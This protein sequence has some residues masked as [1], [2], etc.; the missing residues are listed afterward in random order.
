MV[1]YCLTNDSDK[2]EAVGHTNADV[3]EDNI[4]TSTVSSGGWNYY[5]QRLAPKSWLVAGSDGG[6]NNVVLT[7]KRRCSRAM[8]EETGSRTPFRSMFSNLTEILELVS[9]ESAAC[10]IHDSAMIRALDA[11]NVT[12]LTAYQSPEI[13]PGPADIISDDHFPLEPIE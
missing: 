7:Y 5:R 11:D 1:T 13:P 9:P 2:V 3:V 12:F 4:V 6:L 8:R 10:A